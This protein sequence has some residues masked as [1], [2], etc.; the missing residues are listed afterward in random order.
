M[1]QINLLAHSTYDVEKIRKNREFFE[2]L[3]NQIERTYTLHSKKRH[4]EANRVNVQFAPTE[5]RITNVF[6][7]MDEKGVIDITFSGGNKLKELANKTYQ[8]LELSLSTHLYVKDINVENYKEHL[9]TIVKAIEYCD[10]S[11]K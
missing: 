6:L 7:K 11:F 8:I 5:S 2:S 9:P 4:S 1:E 3:L 10:Y